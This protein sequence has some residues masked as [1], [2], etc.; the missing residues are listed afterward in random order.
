MDG[1]LLPYLAGLM[2]PLGAVC[3][4]PLYPGYVALLAG[5]AKDEGVSPATIGV[6][7]AVGVIG[8]MFAF[9][10]IVS[11]V[12]GLSISAAIGGIAPFLY[13]GL[14]VAGAAMVAGVDLPVR[15]PVAEAPAVGGA[16]VSALLYGAFFGL[17]ALPCNPGPIILL[18]ALSADTAEWAAN[19]LYFLLFGLGMAT[20]LLL[21]SVLPAGWSRRV[22]A[23]LARHHRMV[24][25]VTGLFLLAV[26]VSYLAATVAA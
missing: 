25:R 17:I 19:L 26:A 23:A 15:L 20:P 4:I 1:P 18:F 13:A 12:L 9:G 7:V 6:L 14:A 3:V 22:T 2:T 11:A 24:F 5:S 16:G 8:G 10:L 21:L